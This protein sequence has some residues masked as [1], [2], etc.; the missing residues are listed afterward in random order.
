MF[1]LSEECSLRLL[2]ALACLLAVEVEM[3][4]G[5]DEKG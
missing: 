4:L 1:R 2:R 3:L 5:G